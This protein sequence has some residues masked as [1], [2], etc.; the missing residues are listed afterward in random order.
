VIE[1]DAESDGK[2]TGGTR[3]VCTAALVSAV[4]VAADEVKTGTAYAF[5]N[6]SVAPAICA[7]PTVADG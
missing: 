3:I 2:I 7:P 4:P 6:V 5:R 1:G